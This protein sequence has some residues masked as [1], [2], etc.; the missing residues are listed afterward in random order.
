[1][2]SGTGIR[3]A[4]ILM[5][6]LVGA[7]VIAPGVAFAADGD[8][9]VSC[10]AGQTFD[11]TALG[12]VGSTV[13]SAPTTPEVIPTIPDTGSA[14][15]GSDAVTGGN[16]TTTNSSAAD[17]AAAD[18][19]AADKVA[20]ADKA[21]EKAA[22]A[23]TSAAAAAPPA[24]VPAIATPA[25]T[26]S[27][28]GLTGFQLPAGLPITDAL[29]NLPV[30]N[31][32]LGNLP[33]PALPSSGSFTS[34]RDACLFLASRVKVGADAIDAI[35]G[36]FASF[37]GALPGSFGSSSTYPDLPSLAHA[38]DRLCHG[39]EYTHH[40]HHA[41]GRD[42][43]DCPEVSYERAQQI[44]AEDSSDPNN[45]DGDNDGE[46]CEDNPRD[47]DTVTADYEGYPQGG[48]AT[49]DS[50]PGVEP[51]AAGALAGLA[52]ATVAGTLGRREEPADEDRRE[53]MADR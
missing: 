12:C 35:S 9:L 10:S 22:D 33:I 7:A 6:G 11:P 19:A 18:K 38:L 2:A 40:G 4:A 45:L 28:A 3:A 49:G 21:A 37:C 43:V 13:T 20:A 15:G 31:L 29:K 53:E 30:G 51:G 14:V 8:T 25:V 26:S 44:L 1:M 41:D 16:T 46:A 32:N 48:V 24:N 52:L 17:K 42:D 50:A 39:L 5:A 23:K 34:P 36:Q 27:L 47:Y